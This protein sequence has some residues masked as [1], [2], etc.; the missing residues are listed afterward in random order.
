MD[1]CTQRARG[2]GPLHAVVGLPMDCN[3]VNI[4]KPIPRSVNIEPGYIEFTRTRFLAIL[5]FGLLD[6]DRG[7]CCCMHRLSR[8]EF[9]DAIVGIHVELD[10]PDL[11]GNYLQRRLVV[12][13]AVI[14]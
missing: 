3:S 6:G 2:P 14:I 7:T 10:I 9:V 12:L 1:V 11:P 4:D 13:D 5:A 8:A